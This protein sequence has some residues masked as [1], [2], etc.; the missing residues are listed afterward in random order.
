MIDEEAQRRAQRVGF[1][2]LAATV[3]EARNAHREQY[4]LDWDMMQ[5][6][7]IPPAEFKRFNALIE[8]EDELLNRAGTGCG[9]YVRRVVDGGRINN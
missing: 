8:R 5:A 6:R 9:R 3:F 7:R 2:G 1:G 4:D